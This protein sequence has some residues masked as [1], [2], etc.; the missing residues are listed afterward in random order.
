MSLQN[1]INKSKISKPMIMAIFGIL[2]LVVA[3]TL[4]S[5]KWGVG[6]KIAWWGAIYL[7]VKAIPFIK[8]PASILDIFT[9]IMII[10]AIFDI[11]FIG[12][13]LAIIWLVQK[14]IFSFF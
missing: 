8:D 6:T 10:L 12:T 5:L 14:A 3:G 11:Y 9:A 1:F 2:D 7:T 13:Y 4:I